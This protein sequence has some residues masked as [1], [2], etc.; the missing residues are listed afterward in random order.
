[1][2]EYADKGKSDDD[3]ILKEARRCYKLCVEA[4]GDN[5][6]LALDDLRFL[7]GGDAQWE[8]IGLSQRKRDGRPVITVNSL[9][10]YLHQ[11]TN[12]Q[13]QNTP[14]IKV[15]P[16]GNGA[17]E[18]TAKVRQGMIRHIE[19]DSNSDVAYDRA[20][21]SAAAVGFGYWRLVTEYESETGFD[22][23]IMFKSVRNALSVK[24][25]PLSIE[26]DGSDMGYAFVENLRDREDF[27]AEWPK[28][29]ANNTTLINEGSG[30]Y[31]GWLSD[32]TVLECEYYR[33][34]E[35]EEEV[36]L[37]SNGESGFKSDLI[38]MPPGVSIVKERKGTKRKVML[39]KITGVD[40]LERTEIKCKW[41]PVFPVYGDEIDIEGKVI[42]SGIIRNA[43]GPAQSYNV[44]MSGA[45]EEI[46]LR[47][48]APF[49]GAAGQFAGHEDEWEQANSRSFPFLEYEPVTSDGHLAP[50]PQRQPMADIP[51][52]MLAMAMHAGDNVKMTAGVF[53]GTFQGRLGARGTATS[54]IQEQKQQQQ[55]EIGSYHY[56]DGLNK[57]VLHCGRCINSMIPHY[58]DAPRIVKTLSE[59]DKI[60][61]AQINQPQT[62]RQEDPETG[63]MQAIQSV[64][65]DM[66]A[67]EFDV[68][69][70]AGPSYG[71]MR[72]ESAEFFANAMQSAKDP[73]TAAVVTYLAMK[74]Q[75]V[76]GADEATKMLKKLIPAGIAEPEKGEEPP[77][78]VQ[79]PQGPVPAPQAGQML[80]QL[81]EQLQQASEALQKAQADKQQSEVMKQQNEAASLAI[82]RDRVAIERDQ[83][84]RDKANDSIKFAAETAKA[85]AEAEKYKAEQMR[86]DADAMRTAEDARQ[87]EH[88][89]RTAAE[90]KDTVESPS[91]EDIAQL[92]IKSRQQINGMKITAPS[93]GVYDVQVSET[94]Q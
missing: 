88:D 40:I 24:I 65:N 1:M 86:A 11:V 63:Q 8:P 52:G 59:D 70:S 66:T 35:T 49:I 16:A 41:I 4:E 14:T 84:E 31:S 60:D 79:T 36:V 50:P 54:G 7:S 28:A 12:E 82:E 18:E 15:H 19:Y 68:T 23:K 62:K 22:Q 51:A 64:L 69:V 30:S 29:E 45:T 61:Y 13:R 2:S 57:S 38:E 17:D 3:D 73:V 58:Y 91:I 74:N 47:S 10:T 44:M 80:M 85:N 26:P 53:T 5:R 55:G 9:P 42:R 56:T 32:Q 81:T 87:K 94:L 83:M 25:D 78:M 21:N 72:Q 92:I 76:P 71:T 67:G 75:D 6:N 39:Y 93:G 89:S 46:A 33:I 37:L 20:V 43:K 77:P 90:E 48:K 34:V 27:K